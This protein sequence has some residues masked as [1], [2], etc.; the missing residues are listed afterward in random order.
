MWTSPLLIN[1]QKH[2]A[3]INIKNGKEEMKTLGYHKNIEG[4]LSCIKIII[5]ATKGFRKVS[6]DKTLFDDI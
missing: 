3:I 6:L 1:I 5:Q 2:L 4:T